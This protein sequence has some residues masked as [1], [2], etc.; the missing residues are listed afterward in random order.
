MMQT[1]AL[2][3]K[4]NMLIHLHVLVP[5]DLSKKIRI[6]LLAILSALSAQPL[7]LLAHNV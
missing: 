5:Q 1:L 3:A 7:R 2:L 4:K 6:A